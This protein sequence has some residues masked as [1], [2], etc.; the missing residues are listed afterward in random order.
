MMQ[1]GRIWLVGAMMVGMSGPAVAEAPLAKTVQIFAHRGASALRPEHTLASYAKAIADGADF[2]EP[3]LVS[4]KDGV[5][6]ARHENEIGGTTDVA[7]HSEFAARKTRKTIDGQSMEGWFTE[8]FTLNELKTLRAR[9]RLPQLR[10]TRWDGQFQIV[11]F[12]EIIDFVA[13]ESAATGRTVGLIPE[14]KHPSYF[15]ALGLPMEDKVLATLQAHAYTRTAPVV[16]QSFETGNLRYLRGKIG[17]ASNL[18]L[19]QLLGGAQM[20]LPDAGK[21]DAPGT[22]AQLMTPAGLKQVASYA[23]AIGPDIRAIIP[24]DAQQRLGQPTS[25]VHD[26]HAAGLQVQPYTF[27]PENYFLSADN[28]SGDAPTARNEAGAL[29]ELQ[30]YLA[31][32][33]DAFFA[34][35]PGLARRALH[36]HAPR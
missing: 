18:R 1:G 7:S 27:R 22:Y 24:L 30:R 3:D 33:I 10:G 23:D 36:E 29:A 6:V 11:T 26:A 15:S 2:V 25:L 8:D 17:R 28:R 31:T 12:D 35:D 16:I 9:E 13:A 14:I 5:L 20:P 32:G 19:L 4:T 21:G 34:D